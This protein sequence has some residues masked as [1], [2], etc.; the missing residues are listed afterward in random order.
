MDKGPMTNSLD[1][2]GCNFSNN[3]FVY[4]DH[5]NGSKAVMEFATF[6]WLFDCGGFMILMT[7]ICT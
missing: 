3:F 6:S 5:G 2:I 7:R 1:N 4:C